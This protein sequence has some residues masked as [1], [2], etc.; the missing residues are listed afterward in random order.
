[1]E[2]EEKIE[3]IGKKI[4]YQINQLKKMNC[5]IDLRYNTIGIFD[6]EIEPEIIKRPGEPNEIDYG[7]Q[8]VF[9]FNTSG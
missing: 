9:T 3:K 5:S 7:N 1:M 6:N 4:Q 8:V 2:R